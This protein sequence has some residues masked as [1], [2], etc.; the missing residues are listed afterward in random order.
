MFTL[1]YVWLTNNKRLVYIIMIVYSNNKNIKYKTNLVYCKIKK[2]FFAFNKLL[3]I[4][5]FLYKEDEINIIF[6]FSRN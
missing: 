6:L 3:D 2:R 4:I 5:I 1:I